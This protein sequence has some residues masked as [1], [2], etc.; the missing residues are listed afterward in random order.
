MKKKEKVFCLSMGG[1]SYDGF[2]MLN[3]AIFEISCFN[4]Y[5]SDALDL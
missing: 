4:C 2:K 3:L 5:I 1:R